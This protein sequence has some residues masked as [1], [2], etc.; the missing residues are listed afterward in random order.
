MRVYCERC[1]SG[2]A[3]NY[4]AAFTAEVLECKK[5]GDEVCRIRINGKT[6]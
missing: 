3:S 1:Y 2:I 6:G 4:D 5:R